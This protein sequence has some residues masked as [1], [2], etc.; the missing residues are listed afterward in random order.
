[1]TFTRAAVGGAMLWL[2][3][4]TLLHIFVNL[5]GVGW[6]GKRGTFRVGFLPV[7]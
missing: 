4:I 7:T 6:F 3:T 1:M 2:V 5:G